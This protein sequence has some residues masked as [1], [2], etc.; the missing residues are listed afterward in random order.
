M[1]IRWGGSR[2]KFSQRPMEEVTRLLLFFAGSQSLFVLRL[3]RKESA[4]LL[5]ARLS[6]E[7]QPAC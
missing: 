2:E 4:G 1:A 6:S 3:S 5:L 7:P